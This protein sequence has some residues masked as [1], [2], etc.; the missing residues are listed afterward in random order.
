MATSTRVARHEFPSTEAAR[1]G[2]TDV[3]YVYM[4][5]RFQ[6]ITFTLPIEDDNPDNVKTLLAERAAA[7]EGAGPATIE[8]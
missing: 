3:A 2:K 8:I 6:T 4:D 1:V 5:E 7:A